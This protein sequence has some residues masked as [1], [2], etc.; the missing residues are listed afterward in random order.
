MLVNM[1]LSKA[2]T[3]SNFKADSLERLRPLVVGVELQLYAEL[4]DLVLDDAV[5]R[6]ESRV[7]ALD[8]L[9]QRSDTLEKRR[10]S[11]VE[12]AEPED[13]RQADVRGAEQV[14]DAFLVI[15]LDNAG[16]TAHGNEAE[17]REGEVPVARKRL[18]QERRLP[19]CCVDL[20]PLHWLRLNRAQPEA[21]DSSVHVVVGDVERIVDHVGLVQH[22]QLQGGRFYL[23]LERVP[24]RR[25]QL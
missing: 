14:V 6:R 9:L 20:V 7:D 16:E 5:G 3:R 1:Y 13:S 21:V 25:S 17:V 18:Q 2:E 12:A 11:L 23:P 24:V 8:M 19:P 10:H 4:F 15:S 22:L